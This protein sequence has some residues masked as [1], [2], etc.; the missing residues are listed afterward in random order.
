MSL[1]LYYHPLSSFCHKAL[2][3]LY[4]GE[5]A[6]EPV[7]VNLG[8]EKSSA[9]L[10]AL[11]PI[12]RFPVLR[13]EARDR[14]I[15]EA[16]VIIEYLDAF[17]P[18]AT[19]FVPTDPDLA[20]QT[21]MWDRFYDLYVHT[22]MQKIVGDHLR[23]AGAKDPFGVE[24]AKATL[25]CAYGMIE[26]GMAG[27]TWA[28]GEAYCL[29]DCAASPALFYANTAMPFDPEQRNL[30]AY[31]GRLMARPSYARA[32][33]EAEPYFNLFPMETKPRLVAGQR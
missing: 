17:C 29:V 23:P 22:P 16:T 7:F 5:T 21:R 9:A 28:M 19:R 3:A 31:F 11:W 27:K 2:I 8:D 1:K 13:D 32:L 24:Q 18:G 14:T 10:R 12:A 4:E 20:W 6:F 26:Q 25:K 30:H 15:A 33:K